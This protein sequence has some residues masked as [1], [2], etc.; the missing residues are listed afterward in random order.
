LLIRIN[1]QLAELKKNA[2]T[3][4]LPSVIGGF[5]DAVLSKEKSGNVDVVHLVEVEGLSSVQVENLFGE[6]NFQRDSLA[7]L[8]V[9]VILWIS[10]QQLPTLVSRAPD[11]WSRR[12]AIYYFD[13][14]PIANLLSKIFTNFPDGTQLEDSSISQ[15][16]T[17][18]LTA[19]RELREC[20]LNPVTFS[21]AKAD[22]L[23]QNIRT[24]LDTLLSEC[25]RGKRIE[26]TL[27]LWNVTH[28]DD[29]LEYMALENSRQ[30]EQSTLFF[31]RSGLIIDL[32]DDVE[33]ILGNYADT[34]AERI[35][36]KQLIS[37][38]RYFADVAGS[39]IRG[40]VQDATRE[41]SHKVYIA[42]FDDLSAQVSKEDWMDR[43]FR[44]RAAESFEKWLAGYSEDRPQ[45]FTDE[46]GQI[47][48]YLYSRGLK[49]EQKPPV[50]EAKLL[51]MIKTL[52][53]KV[54]LYLGDV[55]IN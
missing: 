26:V 15:A 22:L 54:R 18:I 16:L 49:D 4:V 43:V 38:V 31:E 17:G 40:K 50:S 14:Y 37:I 8:N 25:E 39:R 10:S 13:E 9:L 51:N 47:L 21:L 46:E 20:L 32:A 42:D 7:R 1:A 2:V 28:M 55:H 53:T 41:Q 5:V 33:I 29:F 52:K 6:L 34:L 23:I 30:L 27:W 24:G 11:F 36:T 44:I 3:L 19:E 45:I 12:T 48:R 35:R